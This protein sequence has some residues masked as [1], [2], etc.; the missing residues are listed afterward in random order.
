MIAN[1][2][3]SLIEVLIFVTILVLF[4][5]AAISIT[6]YSLKNIKIN[7]HKIVATHYAEEGMEWV[8]AE[9]ESGW[10]TFIGQSGSSYCLNMNY[11]VELNW[12]T[13]GDCG[14]NYTLGSP[15]YFKRVVTL[16][17]VGDQINV[18]VTVSW[19][20]GDD[21]IMNVK[22]TTILNLWE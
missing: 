8:K 4:F 15:A 1:K 19:I 21:E 5:V 14:S 7:E 22:I 13:V 16:N 3:F 6:T 11:P 17:S 12:G 10:D 20:E 2:S 9:K 18:V